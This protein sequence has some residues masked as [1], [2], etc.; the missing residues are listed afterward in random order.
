MKKLGDRAF[1]TNR[2]C[3]VRFFPLFFP[4]YVTIF[5][6]HKLKESIWKT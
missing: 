6:D 1:D 2:P 3:M 4:K 5:I